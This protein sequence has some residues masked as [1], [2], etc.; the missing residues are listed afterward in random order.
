VE[1]LDAF[2]TLKLLLHSSLSPGS[3]VIKLFATRNKNEYLAGLPNSKTATTQV[4]CV[5]LNIDMKVTIM[6]AI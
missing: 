4:T 6:L 1:S 5:R 2:G 3:T